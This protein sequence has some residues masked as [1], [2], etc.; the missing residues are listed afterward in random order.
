MT[1]ISVAMATYNGA[2]YIA[3]QLDSIIE[4]LGDNDEIVI[5]DDKSTDDTKKIIQNYA[6]KDDR[7]KL[8]INEGKGIISN[9]ENAINI[10]KNEIVVLC[11]Q[12]DKWSVNK[13]SVIKKYFDSDKEL[14]LLLSDAYITD[15]E[16]NI[17]NDSFYKVR[18]SKS[19]ILHNIIKNSYLGCTMAFRQSAKMFILP[20][21]ENVGMHD[22]WIGNIMEIFGKVSFTPEKLVYYRR[23]KNTVTKI[24]SK[25]SKSIKKMFV[26]RK[27]LILELLKRRNLIKK[28]KKKNYV[29][30]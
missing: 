16:L 29:E 27:N 8:F 2:K 17:V 26:L 12:D 5:S 24:K 11:D 28:G 3:E 6:D 25:K 14:T 7:I 22:I 19:G 18:N 23:H 10:C 15:E 13:L 4:Q 20:I 21:P 30:N 1:S 9:F